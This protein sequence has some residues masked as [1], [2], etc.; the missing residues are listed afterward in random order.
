MQQT[1]RKRVGAGAAERAGVMV[2][3]MAGARVVA[4]AAGEGSTEHRF[5]WQ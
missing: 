2:G 1:G 5:L 3:V 4:A